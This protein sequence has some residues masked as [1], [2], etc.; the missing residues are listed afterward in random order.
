MSVIEFFF[1]RFSKSR[2]EKKIKGGKK[3]NKK[4]KENSFSFEKKL[5]KIL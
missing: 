3:E 5:N 1:F 4:G 2:V